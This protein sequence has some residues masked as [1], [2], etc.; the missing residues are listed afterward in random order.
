MTVIKPFIQ[1]NNDGNEALTDQ[2]QAA[3]CV[4]GGLGAGEPLRAQQLENV[5]Q[6][7]FA[8]RYRTRLIGGRPEP[9]Y[10]PAAAGDAYHR[11]YYREDFFASALHE[12][13][14]WCI[15]GSARR[16]QADYGYWY[17]PDG[18]SPT[19]QRAF[20]QVEQQPQAMEWLFSIACGTRFRISV[21][22]LDA[23]SGNSCQLAFADAVR[24]TALSYCEQGLPPRGDRFFTALQ[25]FF[26]AGQTL[27]LAGEVRDIVSNSAFPVAGEP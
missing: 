17:A 26:R 10:M 25:H 22:N 2:Y 8:K 5:F 14:H 6:Q 15:A 11:I 13:A 19:Q 9:V 3:R 16:L 18:R 1:T 27:S 21:D 23:A 12:V 7:C 4:S 24:R 20:E